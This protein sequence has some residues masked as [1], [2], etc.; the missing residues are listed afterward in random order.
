MHSSPLSYRVWAIAIYLF[1]ANPTGLSSGQLAKLVG[2]TRKSAWHLLH[3]IREN[4]GDKE[5][6]L[7]GTVEA[8]ECYV[9]G[10][11]RSL[12]AAQRRESRL[13]PHWG[14]MVVIGVRERESRICR[15]RLIQNTTE[16]TILNFIA[17]NVQPFT[18]RLYTDG[19]ALY[20][21]WPNQK[22]V[23]QLRGEYVRG[24]VS[25]NGIESLWAGLKRA[26]HG[27][28]HSWSRKHCQRYLNEYC[29]RLNQ[30]ALGTLDAMGAI[31]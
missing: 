8:D 4:Y 17:R 6:L 1:G 9:G 21:H 19:S 16:D 2:I 11:F 26:W 24:D 27:T 30:R 29:V 25:T 28:Y 7:T 23:C 12:H 20:E 15:A 31:V 14:R 5:H 13:Q 10:R 22:S 3:R 18:A